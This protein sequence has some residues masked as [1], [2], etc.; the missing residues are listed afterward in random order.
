MVCAGDV[1][2]GKPHPD[3]Y[4]LGARRLG[5]PAAGCLVVEDAPAGIEAGVAA[6]CQ[7]AAVAHTHACEALDGASAC[8]ED[9]PSLLAAIAS[10]P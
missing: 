8:F 6:G 7:V 2:R 10:R 9:L 3:P 4:L 5:V 1:E